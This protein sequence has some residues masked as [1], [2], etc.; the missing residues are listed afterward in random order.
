MACAPKASLKKLAPMS[1]V[2]MCL[3]VC[4]VKGHLMG[5]GQIG[6]VLDQPIED[7]ILFQIV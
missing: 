5:V 4:M 6:L 3:L 2:M 7:L 1:V